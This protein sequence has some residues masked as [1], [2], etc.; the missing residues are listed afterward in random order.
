M[1]RRF[2]SDL[3]HAARAL[4]AKPGFAF[5]ALLTLALGIGVNAALFSVI[6]AVVF[7]PL[8]YAHADRLVALAQQDTESERMP[9]T[10]GYATIV[11][12]GERAE[13]YLV[14]KVET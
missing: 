3:H 13:P 4:A 10:V 6:K 1:L 2:R 11:A 12:Q 14:D 9:I 7:E 8:P 5:A